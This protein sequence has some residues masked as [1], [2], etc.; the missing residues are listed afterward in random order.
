MKTRIDKIKK[1]AEK[2]IL[3]GTKII[4]LSDV[5]LEGGRTFIPMPLVVSAVHHHLINKRLRSKASI[6]CI[7]GDCIEDHHFAVLIALGASGIYPIGSYS[8]IQKY[9]LESDFYI[10]LDNY[11]HS[12]EKGLLKVM[13]KMGISTLTS[14][15]GSMLLHAI[16]L[17]RKLSKEYFPS[18][19][20]LI[21]GIELEDIEKTLKKMIRLQTGNDN[22]GGLKEI[23]LFRYR[24]SGEAHGI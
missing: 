11:R 22:S 4:F 12:I 9:N 17:G 2:K 15:H 23:G 10:S 19:P 6:V 21:G 3:N 8:T 1:A 7:S 5:A 20:S 18:I 16:G 13:S 24:K 14:Y